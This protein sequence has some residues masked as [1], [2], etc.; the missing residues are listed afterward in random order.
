MMEPATLM[1]P[2]PQFIII[3]APKCGTSWLQGALGQHAHVIVVPDE[4]EYFSSNFTRQSIEWYSSL[5]QVRVRELS[6][7]KATPFLV[8]EK[9]ARYCSLPPDRIQHV[10]NL[11]PDVRLVLMVR[12]PVSRHWAHAKQYFSKPR[13]IE[14]E[15]ADVLTLPRERLFDF[16][17]RTRML[18]EFA[19]M[20]DNWT[21]SYQP[22]QLLIVSQEFALANPRPTFDAVL[23]YLGLPTDYDPASIRLLRKRRNPGPVIEMPSDVSEFLEQM[24]VVERQQLRDLL[25][26]RSIFTAPERTGPPRVVART[27]VV[28]EGPFAGKTVVFTGSFTSIARAE[29]EALVRG[30][31]GRTASSVGDETDLV[32]VG[33]D[34]GSKYRKAQALGIPILNEDEFLKRAHASH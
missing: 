14:R 8:G 1:L 18:G 12:D 10:H 27:A 15:G 13:V 30:L 5:F 33:S 26:G 7:Q 34:P 23:T 28:S 20:I 32:I 2:Y 25:A 9:S 21:S 3:G 29:A 31:G 11:L 16:F 19:A 17:R 6:A 4:I 24:F 22:E